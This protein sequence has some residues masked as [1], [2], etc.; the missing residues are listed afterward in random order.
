[1]TILNSAIFFHLF[2]I[3]VHRIQHKFLM[4]VKGYL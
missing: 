4:Y 2:Q 3:D 1:M